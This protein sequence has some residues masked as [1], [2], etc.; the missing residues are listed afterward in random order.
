MWLR[1]FGQIV[2][3]I[4]SISATSNEPDRCIHFEKESGFVLLLPSPVFN[5]KSILRMEVKAYNCDE[6]S[7][8]IHNG[9]NYTLTVQ[10]ERIPDD[11]NVDRFDIS[12]SC[13]G[14]W[15]DGMLVQC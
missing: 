1:N 8:T 10:N 12:S 15:H 7:L 13:N 5:N 3:I 4:A 6:I 2:L 11:G 9:K 14:L